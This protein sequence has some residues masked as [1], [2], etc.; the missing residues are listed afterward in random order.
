M[1]RTTATLIGFWLFGA[2]VG[3][4][5]SGVPWTWWAGW[6]VAWTAFCTVAYWHRPTNGHAHG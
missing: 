4:A 2:A 3:A 1:S 5:I 6:A